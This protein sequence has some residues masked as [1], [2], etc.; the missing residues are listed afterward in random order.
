MS[1]LLRRLAKQSLSVEKPTIHSMSRMPYTEPPVPAPVQ[2]PVQQPIQSDRL[3]LESRAQSAEYPATEQTPG[4]E[5]RAPEGLDLAPAVRVSHARSVRQ[6]ATPDD[7]PGIAAESFR[8]DAMEV[9]FG[10]ITGNETYSPGQDGFDTKSDSLAGESPGQAESSGDSAAHPR[11]RPTSAH[12]PTAASSRSS[13]AAAQAGEAETGTNFPPP[14][15]A[16]DP[17]GVTAPKPLLTPEAGAHGPR[18]Q[19]ILPAAGNFPATGTQRPFAA[20]H[21]DNTEVH[22]H[23]GRIEVTATHDQTPGKSHERKPA[24]QPMSLD[25]YLRKRRGGSA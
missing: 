11:Y 6:G 2:P 23:I 16:W 15:G 1:G 8:H 19:H 25:E 13:N 14:D 3:E 9:A 22:V 10:D 7:E 5:H 4:P 12:S 21:T 18:H 24:R 20:H 17:P